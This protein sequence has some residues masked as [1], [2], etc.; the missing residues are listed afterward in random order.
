MNIHDN[1]EMYEKTIQTMVAWSDI[2]MYRW[3]KWND[4]C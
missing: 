3:Q 1:S 2:M 4:G